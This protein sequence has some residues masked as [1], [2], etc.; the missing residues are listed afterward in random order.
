M[1][2]VNQPENSELEEEMTPYLEVK[3]LR[4]NNIHMFSDDHLALN[5]FHDHLMIKTVQKAI[6]KAESEYGPA[7]A[8]FAFFTMGSAARFEQSIW[9]DQDHGLIFAG[10]EESK[11]YFLLLGAEIS[12]GLHE[13]GYEYCDGKVMASNTKWCNSISAWEEQLTNWLDKASWETLRYFSTFYDSRVLVGEEGFLRILKE[14]CIKRLREEPYLYIR[15]L[16]N[17]S[18]VK[19]GIGIL[20]QFLPDTYGK[21][22]GRL[23]LKEVIFFPY[24]NS[25]RLL[26][27]KEGILDPSTVSRFEKLH[28]GYSNIKSYQSHFERLLQLRLLLKKDATNY[29]DV[30]LLKLDI[31]TKPEKHELKQIMKKGYKLFQETK[32]IIHKGCRI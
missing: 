22:A 18:H 5:N 28:S 2:V 21:V 7:P 25:I 8:H 23:N 31:L 14:L 17:I 19:K 10:S 11:S 9:S 32:E 26:A 16:N 6:D 30:H 1:V 24:V 20:G 13:V 4:D 29:G 3:Q 15:L 27:L 12:K